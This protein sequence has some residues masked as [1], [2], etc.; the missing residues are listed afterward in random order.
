MATRSSEKM[1]QISLGTII[2]TILVVLAFAVFYYLRDVVLVVIL[3][4]II[5]SAV[6][7]GT[8]WFLRRGVP[9][10]LSVLLMYF[11]AVMILVMVF[12]FLFCR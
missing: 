10:I 3:A 1:I 8:Q 6:E 9:R 5:A 12:Y 7:P 4:V 2:K 11:V